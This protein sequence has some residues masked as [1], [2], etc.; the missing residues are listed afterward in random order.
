[1]VNEERFE[2][3]VERF[4]PLLKNPGGH[5]KYQISLLSQFLDHPC[6]AKTD[7]YNFP[8]VLMVELLSLNC[9]TDRILEKF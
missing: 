9:Q 6:L 8:F 1:M 7:P 5:I 3:R 2:L 4:Y